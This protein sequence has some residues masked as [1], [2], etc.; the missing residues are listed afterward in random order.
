MGCAVIEQYLQTISTYRFVT[1]LAL[2][3]FPFYTR[4]RRTARRAAWLPQDSHASSTDL[5]R[6]FERSAASAKRVPRQALC[7]V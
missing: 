3:L 1:L 2:R 4:L 6:L 7:A 5:P